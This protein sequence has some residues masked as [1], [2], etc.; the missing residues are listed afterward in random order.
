M[1]PVESLRRHILQ[2]RMLAFGLVAMALL[3]RILV[4]AGMMPTV[5]DG[6]ISVRLC[7]AMGVETV[8]VAIPGVGDTTPDKPAI[9]PPACAFAGLWS[10]VV[11]ATDPILLALAVIFILTRLWRMPARQGLFLCPRLRPPLRGPPLTA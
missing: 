2:C 10:P 3:A 8:R 4:P 11:P 7:T 9:D 6:G 1:R 5:S